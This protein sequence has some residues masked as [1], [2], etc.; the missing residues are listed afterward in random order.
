M[1]NKLN[2]APQAFT[3][4]N[5]IALAPAHDTSGVYFKGLPSELRVQLYKLLIDSTKL[6]KAK[7]ANKGL[8]LSCK[9]VKAKFETK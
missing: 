9:T 8:I 3:P 1:V 2:M 6:H 7:E 5:S 4:R